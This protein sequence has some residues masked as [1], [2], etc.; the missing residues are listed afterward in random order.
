[1]HEHEKERWLDGMSFRDFDPSV[2][3]VA[4]LMMVSAILLLIVALVLAVVL[5]EQG[6]GSS[7]RRGAGV[8]LDSRRPNRAAS[9]TYSERR[10]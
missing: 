4:G 3:V 2:M 5:L 7:L 9:A 6:C 10:N 8:P 1:M